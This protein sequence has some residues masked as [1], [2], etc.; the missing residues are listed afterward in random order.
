VKKTFKIIAALFILML[1]GLVIAFFILRSQAPEWPEAVA[2]ISLEHE[3]SLLNE[4]EITPDNAIYYLRRM[5]DVY[6]YDDESLTD[7]ELKKLEELEGQEEDALIKFREN[8]FSGVVPEL[9]RMTERYADNIELLMKA[10]QAQ[11]ARGLKFDSIETAIPAIGARLETC[12]VAL[13][14]IAKQ[15]QKA[16][17]YITLFNAMLNSSHEATLI[18][19]LVAAGG[20][21]V[22]A[23]NVVLHSFNELLTI[24]EQKKLCRFLET[25]EHKLMPLS[26]TF[27]S[28]KKLADLGLDMVFKEIERDKEN[29][30]RSYSDINPGLPA[31][32]LEL[33]QFE[34]DETQKH[35]DDFYT[36]YVSVASDPFSKESKAVI[37]K[38]S[39]FVE[40]TE[41]NPFATL[42]AND[43]LGRLMLS[44]V[45]PSFIEIVFDGGSGVTVLRTTAV[46]LAVNAYKH[47]KG[48][49]P[50]SLE[51]LVP[52]YLSSV[53]LD[54]RT[55]DTQPIQYKVEKN[56]TWSVFTVSKN[57][58]NPYKGDDEPYV[59]SYPPLPKDEY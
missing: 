24:P 6:D 7:E 53:P 39:E 4:E 1:I 40:S 8:G 18:S 43:P 32:I 56:G 41:S 36:N 48:I 49:L 51:Q 34:R 50:K 33:V 11:F 29:L 10:G 19:Y 54:P 9:D 42:V 44:V 28:E 25:A 14:T 2:G 58:H 55:G 20:I 31:W 16:D 57:L 47:E 52:H 17:R 3:V 21:G 5:K 38:V 59:I 22:V 26:E 27:K 30:K 46:Y 15:D 45:A 37:S 12:K 23:D 35:F 13:Y